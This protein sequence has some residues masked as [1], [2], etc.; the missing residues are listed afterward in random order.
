MDELD[1]TVVAVRSCGSVSLPLKGWD[2]ASIWGWDDTT[3]SLYARLWRNTDDAAK[4]PAAR[5]GPDDY[6]PAI[7]FA[8]TL[9]QHIAIATDCDP[10]SALT[11]LHKAARL[12]SEDVPPRGNEGGTVVTMSQG[13]SLPDWPYR[14]RPR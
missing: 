4:P 7:T 2:H 1:E 11:A 3:G 13:Y 8:A 9:A 12:V 6:T 14:S 10:W 5:I